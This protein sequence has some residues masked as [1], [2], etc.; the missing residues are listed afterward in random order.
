[1]VTTKGLGLKSKW[2][3][4]GL[5]VNAAIFENEIEEL[6]VQFISLLSG[7]AVSLRMPVGRVFK[8]LILMCSG[9]LCRR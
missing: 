4:G 3:K 1:M 9:C 6:Q 5:T 8:V 2:F 7:G